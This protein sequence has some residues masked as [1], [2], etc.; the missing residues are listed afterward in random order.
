MELNREATLL[1]NEIRKFARDVIS[2]KVDELD[3]NERFPRDELKSLATMGMLGAVIPENY[4]GVALDTTGLVVVFEEISKTCA[5][6]A[7]ILSVHNGL[8]VYPILKF[9]ND[10]MKKKYLPIASTGEIIGGFAEVSTNE[11]QIKLE[12]ENYLINGRNPILLNGDGGGPF[13]IITPVLENKNKLTPFLFDKNI[14]GYE[15]KKNSNI[16]GMKSAGICEVVFNNCIIPKTNIIGEPNRG[17]KILEE[18]KSFVHI[19]FAAIGLGIAEGSLENAIKYAKTRVQFGAPIINFGMIREKILEM[20]TKIEAARLLIY[21]TAFTRDAGKDYTKLSAIARYFINQ[22]VAEITTSAIQ[23]YGGYG[24]MKDYPV[25]RYF[26]DAQVIRTLLN[27][28]PQLK[29]L[30]VQRTI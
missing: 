21:D 3:K 20:A 23:I 8:F 12:G 22:A 14:S 6:I 7:L 17:T 26:R 27:S 4:G 29:E 16:I 2:Q 15:V 5:S 24:Y 10:E 25:E 30:I 18:I 9:G 13:I 19:C 11:L 28:S 1:Q